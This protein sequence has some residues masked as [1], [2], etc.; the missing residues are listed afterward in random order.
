MLVGVA[1]SKGRPCPSVTGM[2]SAFADTGASKGWSIASFV[3][4]ASTLGGRADER[5]F[6][7]HNASLRP[8]VVQAAMGVA[9]SCANEARLF[10]SELHSV[11]IEARLFDSESHSVPT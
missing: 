6:L 11:P 4:Q 10:D 7:A 1:S 3:G 9:D 5:S 2:T 8:S